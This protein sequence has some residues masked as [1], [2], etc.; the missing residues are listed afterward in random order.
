VGGRLVG[1]FDIV[2]A[3][4]VVA[5]RLDPL[6]CVMSARVDP[7]AAEARRA[8]HVRDRVQDDAGMSGGPRGRIR[9]VGRLVGA[10]QFF[11]LI[12]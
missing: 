8:R 5:S 2:W 1:S 11:A 9:A 3:R 7:A 4:Y 6:F 10:A 12:P